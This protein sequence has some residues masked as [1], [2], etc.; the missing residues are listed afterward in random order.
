MF[1][2]SFLSERVFHVFWDVFSAFPG[3]VFL[4]FSVRF[5]PFSERFFRVFQLLCTVSLPAQKRFF[6]VFRTF[7]YR[8]LYVFLQFSAPFFMSF[9]VWAKAEWKTRKKPPRSFF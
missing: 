1:F 4:P 2:S 3:T 6:T 7:V 5:L 8:F 9:R